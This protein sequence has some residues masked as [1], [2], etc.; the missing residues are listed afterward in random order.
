MKASFTKEGLQRRL[1]KIKQIREEMESKVVDMHVKLQQGNSKTG[2]NCWTVSLLPVFDCANCSECK[3]NCYD[4]KSDLIYPRVIEDRCRNSLIHQFDIERYWRE[5]D[6]QVKANFVSELRLNVG[7]DFRYKDFGYIADLGESNPKTRI[8]F[9][10]KN[11]REL[12]KFL[13]ERK[14]PNNVHPIMSAWEGME[15]E[16]PHNLPCSHLLY[17]DGRTTAPAYGAYY[18]TGNCSECAYFDK[19]C[20]TL[21]ENEHVIFHAH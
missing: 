2:A 8:L 14:F 12:N 1:E 7:G 13:D 16:N 15:M 17:D 11:Y 6:I 3:G 19:G 9:F 21:K 5:I 10:T 4:L 18:C 20:W